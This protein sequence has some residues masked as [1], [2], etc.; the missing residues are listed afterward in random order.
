V[1]SALGWTAATVGI[2]EVK[3]AFE[4]FFALGD[5]WENLKS[6]AT[7]SQ[8]EFNTAQKELFDI[9]QHVRGELEPLAGFYQRT[10]EAVKKLG[11]TQHAAL[12]LTK[13]VA[14]SYKISGASAAESSDGIQQ[15]TQALQSGVLAGDEFRTMM[16]SS[17][18]LAKALTDALHV[19]IGELRKMAEDQK[20]TTEVVIN[21]LL[22][23]K[24]VIEQEYAQMPATVEG[25]MQQAKNSLLKYIGELN[26]S[27]KTT[28][29]VAG[30]INAVGEN[31]PAIGEGIK[32]LAEGIAVGMGAK[33]VSAVLGF[34]GAL[35]KAKVAEAEAARVA[36]AN[37]ES[38]A[39]LAAAE[40]KAAEAA[41]AETR[42]L[43]ARNLA[44]NAGMTIGAE[45]LALKARLAE[46]E[47]ALYAADYKAAAAAA[48]SSAAIA[49]KTAKLGLLGRAIAAIPGWVK[50]AVVITGIE[51]LPEAIEKLDKFVKK[52]S[53]AQK[54][55]E[56]N[57]AKNNE[58]T[59]RQIGE[60]EDLIITLDR[61]R[62]VQIKSADEVSRLSDSERAAYAEK[63]DGAQRYQKALLDLANKQMLL[64]RD[65]T[66]AQEQATAA[67]EKLVNAMDDVDKAAALSAEAVRQL[68]SLDAAK[69][70]AQ[71][72]EVKAKGKD[73]AQALAEIG[74]GF[75]PG[76]PAKMQAFGQ[77]L[78]ELKNTGKISAQEMRTEF[79]AAIGKL[80]PAQ[81]DAFSVAMT[82]AFGQGK[83]DVEALGASADAVAMTALQRLGVDAS[84][85]LTGLSS[86][87]RA[88]LADFDAVESTINT[89][90]RSA[91]EVGKLLLSAFS[92]LLEKAKTREDL[93]A[94]KAKMDALW[95]SGKVGVAEMTD[96]YQK[97]YQASDKVKATA[98][99]LGAAQAKA[100]QSAAAVAEAY[101]NG[102]LTAELLAKAAADAAAAQAMVGKASDSAATSLEAAAVT[103][104]EY[105]QAAAGR[106]AAAR[107]A[108]AE[109][110]AQAQAARAEAASTI[111]D[112][113]QVTVLI[114]SFSARMLEFGEKGRAA[115]DR[116]AGGV[117]GFTVDWEEYGRRVNVWTK[118]AQAELDRVAQW[119]EELQRATAT[120]ENLAGVVGDGAIPAFEHLDEQR[121]QGLQQ[122]LDAAR[123]KMLA[124]TEAAQA[125]EAA[126][127][128]RLYQM[129]G[130]K[131]A[132]ENLRYEQE[133]AELK[134]KQAEAE[135]ANSKE[136]AD[137][138]ARTLA[139]VQAVH[140]ATL[141]NI[142][143][144]QQAAQ[145]AQAEKAQAEKA[146][147][148]GP[149]KLPANP[150]STNP[151]P[152]YER[153]RV[154]PLTISTGSGTIHATAPASGAATIDAFVRQLKNQARTS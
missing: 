114:D 77:A 52:H 100:A 49:E 65:T 149:D 134:K 46:Q 126:S 111:Q 66:S 23:Q 153:E 148:S 37:A 154:I 131:T 67:Y 137:A 54:A 82:A 125:A 110:S 75:D 104:R 147:P 152:I 141:A 78:V 150:P 22:S 11:Q 143:K 113:E 13:L 63:L 130:D 1:R 3:A 127:L 24:D 118:A 51:L 116:L 115:I 145:A 44:A 112:G 16:E 107:Q 20:L 139:N 43:L 129:Q 146:G 83:R 10:E 57:T 136:A 135:K 92:G 108:A 2:Y 105:A 7:G 96:A 91:T 106:A 102:A 80:D 119:T 18:R 120:G 144:E 79:A 29:K 19:S 4:S 72:D 47:A 36:Q 28:Q 142:Q 41:I 14:E 85:V 15:L 17:P 31:L 21:A 6:R 62:D 32:A 73:A 33:A 138:Y 26:E 48:A 86:P 69:L 88:L 84:Q 35:D 40:A 38:V 123:Q 61:C 121:L 45:S 39:L 97:W 27:T 99:E 56:A 12:D 93:D 59:R 128:D 81:L 55:V 90:G 89:T 95:Q 70:I 25:A 140:D 117:Q 94:I 50:L 42:A 132:S 103:E 60:L 133:V 71:F 9:A 34:I 68:L 101:K 5:K 64:G 87:V 8:A 124:L 109:Q 98:A 58:A 151:G 122:A 53:E 74:K 76:D 30:A